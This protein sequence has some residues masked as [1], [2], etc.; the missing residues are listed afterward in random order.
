MEASDQ[1][2]GLNLWRVGAP[3][4]GPAGDVVAAIGVSGPAVRVETDLERCV[5]AAREAVQRLSALDG[6]AGHDAER[7]G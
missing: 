1:D 5:A 2:R 7:G 3:V 4:F 6:P